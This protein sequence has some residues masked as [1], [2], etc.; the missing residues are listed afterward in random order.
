MTDPKHKFRVAICGGGI[1]GLTLAVALTSYP[2]IDVQVYE[3]AGKLAEI[4]AGV[5]IWG[6]T[7]KILT[8]LGLAPTLRRVAGV[9]V[10][11]DIEPDFGFEFRRSDRPEGFT[12]FRLSLPFITY[13]FHRAHFLN[14]LVERLPANIAHLGKR[15]RTY[16]HDT[17]SGEIALEFA[18]GSSATCDIL[19]GSDGIKSAVRRCMYE[20]KAAAG[21]P[22]L[23]KHVEP[24]FT[25]WVV[26]RSL[27]PVEK[28]VKD[29]KTHRIF[30]QPMM[31]CGVHK[32]VVSYG[33]A[34]G[35]L[36]NVVGFHSIP[37]D[38]N[39]TYDGP[40][41]SEVLRDEVVDRFAGWEPELQDL[42]QP[43]EKA[44]K[45]AIHAL[46]PLP[47]YLD[48]RV[49]LLGDAAHAMTPHQGAG[50]G[51]AVED[52]YVLAGI[53]GDP[54]TTRDTLT[55]ALQAYD[56]IRVPFANHVL[57]GSYE[58]GR[59]YEFWNEEGEDYERLP[60]AISHQWDWVES[61]T[62]EEQIEKALRWMRE[63]NMQTRSSD[64]VNDTL[65]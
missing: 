46:H 64:H 40:W 42:I 28:L 49:A 8:T 31:Y 15:L 5:M 34:N 6:R 14:V 53:L 39:T 35:K 33:I 20:R 45:W 11:K 59:M 22:E 37:V 12:F 19:I 65:N 26:Y 55:I 43:I 25:G 60:H 41:V 29:E 48:G 23:L 36:G 1:G 44:L 47:T 52:A 50:A 18:D 2:D 9:S 16:S 61:D 4:G 63:A 21:K 32:H 27:V 56:R 30:H 54:S 17:S 38:D 57:K 24:R 51:Q 13:L 10:D 58:S 7:W 3:A 62:P